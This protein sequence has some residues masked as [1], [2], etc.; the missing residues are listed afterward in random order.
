MHRALRSHR[1]ARPVHLMR[2]Y[3]HSSHPIYGVEVIGFDHQAAYDPVWA[4][5]G[6][7]SPTVVGV[8]ATRTDTLELTGPN[9]WDG[10]THI[11]LGTLAGRFRLGYRLE[12]S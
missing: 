5:V 8:G 3:P 9:M 2:C 1:S 7:D 4:C 12:E 11:P 6:H 10:Y